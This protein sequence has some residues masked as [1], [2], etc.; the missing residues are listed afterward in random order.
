MMMLTNGDAMMT[1][2]EYERKRIGTNF[3]QVIQL[4][5][6]MEEK[7]SSVWEFPQKQRHGIDQPLP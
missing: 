3:M 5:T 4:C 7:K 2:P 1:H 6:L